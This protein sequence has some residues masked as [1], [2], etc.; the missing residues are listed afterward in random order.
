MQVSVPAWSD[1]N[2]FVDLQWFSINI[3]LSSL[4]PWN[5]EKSPFIKPVPAECFQAVALYF[6]YQGKNNDIY[7]IM[8]VKIRF[9]LI[10]EHW[11]FSLTLSSKL[12]EFNKNEI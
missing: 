9:I 7:S 11:I 1:Y 3:P 8:Q 2:W 12:A 10:F 5:D 4:Q 6:Y